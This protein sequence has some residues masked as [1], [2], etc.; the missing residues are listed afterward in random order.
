MQIIYWR[1]DRLGI[2]GVSDCAATRL[3]AISFIPFRRSTISFY[4]SELKSIEPGQSHNQNGSD[5]V[6]EGRLRTFPT[7]RAGLA[8]RGGAPRQVTFGI[9][10]GGSGPP[11]GKIEVLG[12][13]YRPP[14]G[15]IEVLGGGV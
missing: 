12:G 11:R 14:R 10:G 6:A 2:P 4:V 15:Q 8:P 3:I 1:E 9:V 7:G 13:G 5:G